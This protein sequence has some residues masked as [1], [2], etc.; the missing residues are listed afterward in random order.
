M[1]SLPAYNLG[2]ETGVNKMLLVSVGTGRVETGIG[3][4]EAAQMNMLFHARSIPDALM[5]AINQEQDM[6]CRT[7]GFC[8]VG[9]PIDSEVGDFRDVP[10][11]EISRRKFTYLR[12][13]HAYTVDDYELAKKYGKDGI[14]LDNVRLIPLLQQLGRNYADKH[15]LPEDLL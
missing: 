4:R 8:K 6:M 3:A 1:A 15:V 5:E 13:D 9:E 11:E 7:I 14:A 12:Y 10:V 2:W